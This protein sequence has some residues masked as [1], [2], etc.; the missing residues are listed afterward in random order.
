MLETVRMT[1]AQ[2]GRLGKFS[3][4]MLQ[5]VG[6]AQ[7]LLHDPEL[8]VLD[9]P[10]GGLDPIGRKEFRDIILGLRDAGK[11]VFFSTHILQDVELIC[12]RVGILVAGRLV[13]L[14]RLDAILSEEVEAVELTFR[15]A[16]GEM[17]RRSG[18]E[19]I[20]LVSGEGK[21][22]AV[23]RTEEAAASLLSFVTGHG[24]H[25]ISMAPRTRTL[26]DYFVGQVLTA[27]QTGG[28]T[29]E[30]GR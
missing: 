24:G 10:M 20:S 8:V 11:T 18:I 7:A 9:E 15:C 19:L 29:C 26:E 21:V 28:P 2:H 23:V 6:I 13:S 25:V 1:A 16:D 5:R 30:S 12:D 14:G 27:Q 17:L 3:R 22:M 4:G